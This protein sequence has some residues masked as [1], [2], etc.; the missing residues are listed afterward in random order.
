MILKD[1]ETFSISFDGGGGSDDMVCV[2]M[3]HNPD[4]TLTLLKAASGKQA[5]LI[6]RILTEQNT[7]I[8]E[9]G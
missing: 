1:Y 4:G 6:Y 2:S 7:Q 8:K 3:R 5:E 9:I